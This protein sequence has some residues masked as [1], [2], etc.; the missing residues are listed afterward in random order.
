M[1][2]RRE[3]REGAW[4]KAAVRER[5]A[6]HRQHRV[7]DGPGAR[8]RQAAAVAVSASLPLRPS[9]VTGQAG[10][11]EGTP[12]PRCG[13]AE[14][15]QVD[16]ARRFELDPFH[17]QEMP[18]KLVGV[19]AAAWTDPAPGIDHP[20]PRNV[21]SR[22]ERMKRI[23]DLPRSTDV[24]DLGD[25]S[26]GGHSPT[27]NL[28]NHPVENL[29]PSRAIFFS[30]SAS[31]HLPLRRLGSSGRTGSLRNGLR[32]VSRMF[33]EPPRR[34][35]GRGNARSTS[36]ALPASRHFPL[37]RVLAVGSAFH[38]SSGQGCFGYRPRSSF[39]TSG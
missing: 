1:Y 5:S 17:F 30:L 10:P 37:R 28:P 21:A 14:P 11:G 13:P 4:R 24:R 9:R 2:T 18:L 27:R 39:R 25:L 20:V 33:R 12:G 16:A 3:W 26:I 35:T 7:V 31:H 22:R 38:G 8:N 29:P 19:G 6:A 34:G 36:G 23:P 32:C 15:L